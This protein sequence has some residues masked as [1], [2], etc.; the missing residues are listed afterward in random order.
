MWE[1]LFI[2][3]DGT[4]LTP[5]PIATIFV[6]QFAAGASSMLELS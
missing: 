5:E 2:L 3:L 4:A 1:D 6:P